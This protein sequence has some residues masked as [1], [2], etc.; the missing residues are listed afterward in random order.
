MIDMNKEFRAIPVEFKTAEQI[1]DTYPDAD[2]ESAKE[3]KSKVQGNKTVEK[4][5]IIVVGPNA[6]EFIETFGDKYPSAELIPAAHPPAKPGALYVFSDPAMQK[7]KDEAD[8]RRLRAPEP[9]PTEP[10]RP[11]NRRERRRLAALSRGAKKR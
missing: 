4:V 6:L 8:R 1:K 9:D 11:M 2:T 3:E 5:K 7:A 10:I